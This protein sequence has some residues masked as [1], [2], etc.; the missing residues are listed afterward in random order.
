MLGNGL[1]STRNRTEVDTYSLNIS[2]MCVCA[3]TC[4]HYT[5]KRATRLGQVQV[6][7]LDNRDRSGLPAVRSGSSH[8]SLNK[9]VAC[10]V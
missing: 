7:L 2:Y 9:G 3:V 1:Y 4:V 5:T 8:I 10:S 6:G